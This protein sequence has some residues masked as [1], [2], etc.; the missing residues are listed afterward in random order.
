M[1]YSVVAEEG[2]EQGVECEQHRSALPPPAY[3]D[4]IDGGQLD[5]DG[6]I[7]AIQILMYV[8]AD[9]AAHPAVW[10]TFDPF[11]SSALVWS[12]CCICIF[13]QAACLRDGRVHDHM[14]T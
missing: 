8:F 1:S 12:R 10:R 7:I 13:A 3:P 9:W 2:S 14:I 6:H 4:L 11:L 5:P